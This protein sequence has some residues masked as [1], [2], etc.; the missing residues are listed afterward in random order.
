MIRR[1]KNAV[2]VAG[3]LSLSTLPTMVVVFGLAMLRNALR[4]TDS[5]AWTPI[6]GLSWDIAAAAVGAVV[7]HLVDSRRP[8]RWSMLVAVWYAWYFVWPEVPWSQYPMPPQLF[9]GPLDLAGRLFPSV[10]CAGAGV[11]VA[12]RRMGNARRGLTVAAPDGG[13]R[14]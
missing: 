6:D 12:Q 7:A 5:D 2:I 13:R 11:L 1:V 4:P 3:V 9:G 8:H 10:A 14:G